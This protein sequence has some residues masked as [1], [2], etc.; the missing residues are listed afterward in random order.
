MVGRVVASPNVIDGP[1][2]A[3]FEAASRR[4]RLPF[5]P[6]M[7][8]LGTA[9]LF[10]AGYLIFHVSLAPFLGIRSWVRAKRRGYAG[11]MWTRLFGGSKPPHQGPWIVISAGGLGE[12]RAG[13]SF[14]EKIIADRGAN[15]AVCVQSHN[16]SDLTHTK[17]H[18]GVLPFN[19]PIS[20]M[21]FL[22]RWR[23]RAIAAVEFF[24]NHHLFA[25]ARL[26]GIKTIAFNVPITEPAA[27]RI[28]PMNRWRMLF[29]G[30]YCC[31]G[32][33]HVRRLLLTKIPRDAIVLTGPVG[34]RVD[35][36]QGVGQ[37]E[38]D[39]R[40]KWLAELG[41]S[42]ERFPVVIAGST[43]QTDE[44]VILAA[45]GELR[46]DFPKAVLILAPRMLGRPGGAS[47]NLDKL[48]TSYT[49]RSDHSK[50]VPESGVILVD[51][52]GEL[53]WLYSVGH[54][55]FVGG[56][57][58]PQRMGHTPVEA[59]AWGLPVTIGP[60]YPQQR[61][62]VGMVERAGAAFVC[63]SASELA[64]KWKELAL[65]PEHRFEIARVNRDILS[66]Q[67]DIIL[68]IYDNLLS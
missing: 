35:S 18:S 7:L 34:I 11:H 31:Q 16:A 54:I 24:E 15:V 1:D 32:K 22:W 38:A 45:F 30:A 51:T 27:R 17:A 3:L 67:D 37:S 47:A 39:V 12:K 46:R 42:K 25:M 20:A 43:Y 68:R 10:Y 58:D 64:S 56:T 13:F 50:C 26:V 41:L 52:Y 63:K 21:L 66:N 6:R 36:S 4:V 48:G 29:M 55:A 40:S 2:D 59:M 33:E 23:P 28:T 62:I 57:L 61:T 49:K 44:E 9:V 65:D 60:Y 5:V 53:K 19:N 14:A 8:S